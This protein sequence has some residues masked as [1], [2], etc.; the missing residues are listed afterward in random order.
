[1]RLEHFHLYTTDGSQGGHYHY[2]IEPNT[3]KYTAYFNIAKQLIKI[4]QTQED[5]PNW[6][7]NLLKQEN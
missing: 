2:D 3:I 7:I 6:M 4:D 1:L 5:I